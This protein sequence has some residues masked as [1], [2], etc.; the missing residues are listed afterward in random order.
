MLKYN[1]KNA[2]WSLLVLALLSSCNDDSSSSKIQLFSFGP[3]GVKHGDQIKFIG[4][5]LDKVTSIVLPP[6]IEIQASS[7]TSKS[8]TLIEL[9]VP[10]EA[11]A[12][13][14]T[15][16]TPQGDIETKSMLNFLV[17]VVITSI[18]E[19]AKPGTNIS[20]KGTL[21]NWIESV[22]FNDGKVV[23]EFVSKSTE[24]VVVTVP[25]DAKTGFLIFATGGTDPLTFS[26]ENQLTVTL[27]VVTS[28][29]P[30]A[31]KHTENLTVA[32]TDLDLVTQIAFPGGAVVSAGDFVSQSET[33]IVV[34][35]PATSTS[36]AL[37]LTVPSGVEVVTDDAITIILPI[38]TAISPTDP[39]TQETAGTT[40]TFTGTDLDLVAKIK[41]PG[42][43]T[44]VTT[45]TTTGTTQIDVVV[46]AGAQGGTLV[47]TT[48]HDFTV[49]VTVSYGNQLTLLKTIF[50]DNLHSPFA[51]G[52][53]WGTTSA[54]IANT[55]NPR[56]GTVSVKATYGGD[57]GG[58]SQ[59]GTWGNTPLS[60]SGTTYFAFSI[61]G[62]T[63][64][65]GKSINVNVS[66][67]QKQIAIVEG[68]WTDVKILLSDVG[69]PSSISEVWFQDTGWTG[70]VYIDQ[71]GLK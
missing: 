10:E 12:G 52:G 42:V 53:G 71:V 3:S 19:E 47:L 36:G 46:P 65:G 25:M 23:T 30:A 67:Q 33:E 41:F 40:L 2:L 15:L 27:P 50:D 8:S 28:L 57:W 13:K 63:G 45:F 29:S 56:V 17:P 64:T 5:N 44:P 69:S 16:K 55:E 31:I 18:T 58:T 14:V 61:Y 66:G 68:K 24:E 4:Q 70:T 7:F 1:I 48:I 59:F 32:G 38:V 9:V 39:S 62:G 54:D 20:I 51:K 37:T 43:S 60:T 11:V 21:V 6:N 34:A 26:S 22:T 35:V 49:A